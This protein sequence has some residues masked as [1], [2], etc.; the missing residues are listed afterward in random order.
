MINPKT[1]TIK[2]SDIYFNLLFFFFTYPN[3]LCK[4]NVCTFNTFLDENTF[5]ENINFKRIK[6][7]G[8]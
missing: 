5:I 8:Y 1:F 3:K 6:S 7:N 2:R 4:N